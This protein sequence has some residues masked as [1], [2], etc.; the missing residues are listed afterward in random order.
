MKVVITGGTGLLGTALS[1]NLVRDGCEVVVL[2]RH[3][4]QARLP[5]GV[6]AVRWDARTRQGWVDEANGADVIVNFAGENLSSGLWTA[7]RKGRF[8]S[9]RV[10]AGLAVVDAV[11]HS[12][13][14]PG[15]VVQASGIDYY[16]PHGDEKL[17]EASPPGD[18]YLATLCR[19]W[20]SATEK[21]DQ[22]GVRRVILRT[23]VVITPKGGA[24]PL[25]SLPYKLFVGGPVGSGRQWI[26]WIHIQDEIRAIRF[27]I[28]HPETHGPYNLT[29]PNP[30]TNRDFGK[31]LAKVLGRPFWFPAPAFAL[32]LVLGELSSVVLNGQRVIPAR[33]LEAGFQFDDPTVEGALTNLYQGRK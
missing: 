12:Q 22:F 17:T 26:S 23:G 29:A 25:L 8:L 9:S 18:S 20:E 27:L 24:L 4:E 3:P 1:E 30:T 19:T 5:A 33:L 2:S 7:K 28:D 31:A 14:K 11:E 15:L 13:K 6:K 21:V 10:N 16:G 32:R